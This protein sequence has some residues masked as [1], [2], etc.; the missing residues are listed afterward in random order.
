MQISKTELFQQA[1]KTRFQPDILEKVWHLMTLLEA[2]NKDAYLES[3]LALVG[4]TSFD[5]CGRN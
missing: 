4:G 1:T 2:I 3:R 5:N